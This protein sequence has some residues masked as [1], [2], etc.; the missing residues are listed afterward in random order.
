MLTWLKNIVLAFVLGVLIFTP[1]EILLG[2][3]RIVVY[4][5]AE[6]WG[7][8]W[9]L[10]LGFGILTVGSVVIF[11]AVDHWFKLKQDYAP[12]YLGVEYLLITTF[13]LG[14]LF[15][16]SYPYILLITLLFLVLI[17]LIF[18]HHFL[19]EYYFVLGACLG[20]TAEL[21]MSYAG[22]YLFSETDFL[23]MPTW[24]PLLWGNGA[25]AFR[26][27]AWVMAPQRES[28]QIEHTLWQEKK[29]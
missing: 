28:S 20:A 6:W 22:F 14:I 10:P 2:R 9:W 29:T 15:L 19:D 12:H 7:L 24:L 8:P 21:L 3:L 11:T 27:V 16:R 18:F 23:G 13:Y 1:W 5:N 25:L 4:E 17:R 26:R